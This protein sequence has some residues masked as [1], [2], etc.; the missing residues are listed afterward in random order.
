MQICTTEVFS[1]GG[2]RGGRLDNL[3]ELTDYIGINEVCEILSVR[4]LAAVARWRC[5]H[6]S[7]IVLKIVSEIAARFKTCAD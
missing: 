1:S 4:G 3:Y 7:R 6:F 5:K 2:K